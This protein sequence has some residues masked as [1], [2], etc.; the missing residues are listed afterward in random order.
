MNF[1]S[2]REMSIRQYAYL[3][4]IRCTCPN[5]PSEHPGAPC[6]FGKEVYLGNARY[7][8]LRHPLFYLANKW[9]QIRSQIAASLSSP[10]S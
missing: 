9:R 10:T 7:W 2:T 1:T 8:P 3:T 5:G 4:V 6:P